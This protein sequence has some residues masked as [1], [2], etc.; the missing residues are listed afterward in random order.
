MTRSDGLPPLNA[1]RAFE[2]AGRHLSF[3]RAA[4]EL[5]VTQGAVAQQVR[6]LERHFSLKLFHRQPRGLALTEIGR[7]YHGEIARALGQIADATRALNPDQQ[8][9]TISVTPTFAAKWLIPLLPDL[10]QAHPEIDLR[11]LATERVSSFESDS[12]DLV[13]RQARPPFGASLSADLLFRQEIVAIASPVL[14]GDGAP[15]LSLEEFGDVTLLHDAHDLWPVFLEGAFGTS[16]P[17]SRKGLRFNQTALAIDAAMAGQGIALASRFMVQRDLDAGRLTRPFSH[18]LRGE[19]DF[20]LITP[21]AA[22]GRAPIARVRGWLLER[23]GD[24][25]IA[26]SPP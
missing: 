11:L 7:G 8:R 20:Y 25:A 1:L 4:E 26:T 23:R 2:A 5:N 3:R 21:R 10:T 24:D 6:G 14:F 16:P 18:T 13:V 15:T 17:Q 12:V 9:L 19:R 22:L